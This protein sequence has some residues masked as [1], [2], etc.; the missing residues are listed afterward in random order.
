MP[1]NKSNTSSDR[2][3]STELNIVAETIVRN[4]PALIRLNNHLINNER[5]IEGS[6]ELIRLQEAL[7]AKQIDLL[8]QVGMKSQIQLALDD[9][10]VN[11]QK[12][13]I[14]RLIEQIGDIDITFDKELTLLTYAVEKGY[15]DLVQLLFQHDPMLLDKHKEHKMHPFIIAID[16]GNL[17]MLNL[18]LTQD[19]TYP[20]PFIQ[21]SFSLYMS[22]TPLNKAVSLNRLDMVELLIEYGANVN[23]L[24]SGMTPLAYAI[25]MNATAMIDYLLSAELNTST[26]WISDG[27]HYGCDVAPIVV[28]LENGGVTTAMKLVNYER[29]FGQQVEGHIEYLSYFLDN[30]VALKFMLKYL[31]FDNPLEDLAYLCVFDFIDEVSDE[32]TMNRY[33]DSVIMLMNIVPSFRAKLFLTAVARDHIL[34]TSF[35]IRFSQQKN[36]SIDEDGFRFKIT[37][38]EYG[39]DDQFGTALDHSVINNLSNEMHGLLHSSGIR[40][41]LFYHILL[42]AVKKDMPIF[43]AIFNTEGIHYQTI[44]C[45]KLLET[46]LLYERE[47]MIKVL[48]NKVPSGHSGKLYYQYKLHKVYDFLKA[49]SSMPIGGISTVGNQLYKIFKD[50]ELDS[51]TYRPLVYL[52]CATSKGVEYFERSTVMRFGNDHTNTQTNQSVFIGLVDSGCHMGQ[53]PENEK[54]VL[55]LDKKQKHQDQKWAE[56]LELHRRVEEVLGI[57][58]DQSSEQ[59]NDDYAHSAKRLRSI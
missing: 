17:D 28:A 48:L 36:M 21:R 47:S 41:H 4:L 35:I 20:Q 57:K 13:Y 5:A 37:S 38:K 51:F 18:L 6:D 16:T 34:L 29:G 52:C 25:K 32:L 45:A 50:C 2:D 12:D 11:D 44:D 24:S 46:A 54:L 9:L 3:P 59:V 58:S 10:V 43:H 22:D 23:E 27:V 55:E 8:V 1:N 15:T 56:A 7:I 49:K 42:H 53:E 33:A 19:L 39:I 30:P 26:C 31:N 14:I 40:C